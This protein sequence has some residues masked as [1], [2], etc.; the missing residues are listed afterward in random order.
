MTT[1]IQ[2]AQPFKMLSPQVLGRQ[3]ERLAAI[4]RSRAGGVYNPFYPVTQADVEYAQKVAP[5]LDAQTAKPDPADQDHR[6]RI[7]DLLEMFFTLYA[8]TA[9]NL[10]D[11][12]LRAEAQQ[13]AMRAQFMLNGLSSFPVWAIQA[14]LETYT[15]SEKGAFPPK[16]AGEVL[17]F[18]TTEYNKALTAA[19][20]AKAIIENDKRGLNINRLDHAVQSAKTEEHRA[21]AALSAKTIIDQHAPNIHAIQP[22]AKAVYDGWCRIW[23]DHRRAENQAFVPPNMSVNRE[24]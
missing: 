20:R 6:A 12:Q 17:P 2:T 23:S 13:S 3:C 5:Y 16:V 11:A 15:L 18:I 4:D 24:C 21:N 22:E 9:R 1:D 14:G 8:P 7:K 19:A 10:S